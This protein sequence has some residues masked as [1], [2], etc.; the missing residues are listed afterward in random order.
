VRKQYLSGKVPKDAVPPA[1]LHP[2]PAIGSKFVTDG[3]DRPAERMAERAGP[4]HRIAGVPVRRGAA[5]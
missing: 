2:I 3:K 1:F 4:A 5:K